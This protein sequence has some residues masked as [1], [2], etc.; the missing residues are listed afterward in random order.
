MT[1]TITGAVMTGGIA[2]NIV[3]ITGASGATGAE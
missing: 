3:V 1:V 2:A